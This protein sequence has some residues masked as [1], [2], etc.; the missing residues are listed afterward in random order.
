MV[1][2]GLLQRTEDTL[3]RRVKQVALTPQGRALIEEGIETRRSW[4]E[5]LTTALTPNEQ[6]AIIE[7][8]TLLTQAARQIEA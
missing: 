7:A 3:D 5:G 4:M 8:L 2:L 1:Q 6:Q